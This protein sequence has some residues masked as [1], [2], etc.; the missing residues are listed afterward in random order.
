MLS[1][2]TPIDTK[3]YS[4]GLYFGF[5]APGLPN[6]GGRVFKILHSD[7]ID[8]GYEPISVENLVYG[9]EDGRFPTLYNRYGEMAGAGIPLIREGVVGTRRYVKVG[10]WAG[11]E[12]GG[13]AI[14]VA[15]RDGKTIPVPDNRSWYDDAQKT[16]DEIK[17]ICPE[18]ILFAH[19]D[20][21]PES[22][23]GKPVE[24][25]NRPSDGVDIK[26]VYRRVFREIIEKSDSEKSA[27]FKIASYAQGAFGIAVDRRKK[28]DQIIDEILTSIP[29]DAPEPDIDEDVAD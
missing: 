6:G 20:E 28:L 23:I 10:L 19:N 17:A 22:K 24:D 27:K 26:K 5:A 7:D 1:Y 21:H 13:S 3:E 25:A 8:G 18:T 29:D 4:S 2:G 14:A 9:K 16:A 12:R 11:G 15:V